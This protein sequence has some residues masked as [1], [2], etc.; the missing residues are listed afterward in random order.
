MPKWGTRD[1]IAV[2][3]EQD[4]LYNRYAKDK[5]V[6]NKRKMKHTRNYVSKLKQDLKCDYFRKC[7]AENQGNSKKMWSTLN[8][9]FGKN[10]NKANPIIEINGETDQLG[11][12]EQMNEYF[13]T[14]ADK[15]TE[16][17]PNETPIQTE[18]TTNQPK[19]VL[20]HTTAEMVEKLIRGL[21]DATAVGVDGVSPQILKQQSSPCPLFLCNLL[22]NHSSW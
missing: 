13:S 15:L 14:V 6:E 12:A 2:C 1:F 18:P 10:T 11:M 17:F 20:N 9:A 7:L 22:T 19:F 5:S 4:H 21:S 16:D 8:E 3:D